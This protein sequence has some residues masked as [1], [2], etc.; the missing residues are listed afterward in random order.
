MARFTAQVN[1][2]LAAGVL[3]GAAAGALVVQAQPVSAPGSGSSPEVLGIGSYSPI[4][5][6]LE[7]SLRFYGEVGLTIPAP[8][9][10][11]PRLYTLNRG[12][13]HMLGTPD[14]KERHV[15]ARIPGVNMSAEIV[16]LQNVERKPTRLR[17]QD[18]G[19]ITL[20]LLVRDVDAV[21]QTLRRAGT[22]ILTPGGAP[23]T[24][25]DG[26]R[27]VLVEDPDGRPI[28]LSQPNP[29]P[30]TT[31]PAA[32]NVIGA[33][34]IWVVNSTEQTAHVYR[35]VLGG[36]DVE[37]DPSFTTDKSLQAL[38]GLTHAQVR[39]SQLRAPKSPV[40]FELL[41]FKGVDRRPL[42]TQLQDP[43]S[44]RMQ[45]RVR[46]L[47]A[48]VERMKGLGSHVVAKEGTRVPV[49]PNLWVA[50]MPDVNNLFLTLFEPC[51]GCAPRVPPPELP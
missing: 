23:V 9:R 38:T 11:G 27:S 12:L 22:P 26:S 48:I 30:E 32:S 40:A 51:D 16:E 35:D 29:L 31:A 6:D 19:T 3:L 37:G 46:N 43:G 15:A 4:V 36:F 21:L 45:V 39:R 28:V 24:M 49:M 5:G 41:E 13:L 33:R 7:R 8:P 2:V 20:A 1:V 25:A 17:F 10:P 47:D 18:P 14:G 44:T 42:H 34:V 50:V